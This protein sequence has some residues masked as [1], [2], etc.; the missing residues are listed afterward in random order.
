MD[1]EG[2]AATASSVNMMILVPELQQSF[3]L[4]WMVP[5]SHE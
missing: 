3:V 5:V 1:S 4:S 2:I